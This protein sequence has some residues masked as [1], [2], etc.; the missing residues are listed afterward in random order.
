MAQNMADQ[1]PFLRRNQY[2]RQKSVVY[3]N[4]IVNGKYAK[5]IVVVAATMINGW[6]VSICSPSFLLVL[7][8]LDVD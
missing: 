1:G 4:S 7:L 2:W 5:V 3:Q 8:F 6:S